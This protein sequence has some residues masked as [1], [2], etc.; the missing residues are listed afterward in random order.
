MKFIH[1]PSPKMPNIKADESFNEKLPNKNSKVV[2]WSMDYHFQIKRNLKNILKNRGRV[3]CYKLCHNF[4]WNAVLERFYFLDPLICWYY[5]DLTATIML[6]TRLYFLV[7][8]ILH[9]PVDSHLIKSFTNKSKWIMSG[10]DF[11]QKNM[12][13]T[14]VIIL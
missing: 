3:A 10:R 6:M 11:L 4:F 13:K 9:W 14:S 2:F 12:L 8:L 1:I 5:S 7:S